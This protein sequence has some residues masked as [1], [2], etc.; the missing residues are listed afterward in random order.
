[1]GLSDPA[2]L[3]ELLVARATGQPDAVG[4]VFTD[5]D[6]A[7]LALTYRELDA[8]ARAA[9][10]QLQ[11]TGVEPGD[12]VMLLHP[13]GASYVTAFFGCLYAG[14]VAVPVYP[15]TNRAGIARVLAVAEDCAAT[16][17]MTDEVLLPAVQERLGDRSLRWLVP[18]GEETGWSRP[19]LTPDT[20]AF[21]QYT[22]GST[23]TPK[24]VLL[25]HG[26]LLHNSA[27]IAGVLA[28]D[29]HTRSVSWLPPYHDMGLIGGILQPLHSG[30]PGMLM[31]PMAF[32]HHPV[33]WLRA[34]SE[35]GATASAAPDFAYAE[36]VRRISDEELAGLDLSTWRLALVGA[37]PVRAP[38]LHAFAERFGPAGFRAEAF[39]PCYGLAEATL[40]VTGAASSARPVEL[41]VDRAELAGGSVVPAESGATLVGCGTTRGADLVAVV[42]PATGEE[43]PPGAVGEIWVSG[44]TVGAGYWANEK[45]TRRVFHARLAGSEHDWLR[46][47]DLGFLRD[48]ELFVTGRLKELIVVRGANHYPADIEQSAAS[49]GPGLAAGRAA[50]FAVDDGATERVVLV[51]EVARGFA[52]GQPAEVT[53]LV[54]AVREAVTRDHLLELSDVVLVRPG[55]VPR[56]SSGKVRRTACRE[57]YLAGTLAALTAEP[58]AP[59][60][61]RAAGPEDPVLGLVAETLQL[62]H[63]ALHPDRP[64]VGQG[65]D[66]L[67]AVRLRSALLSD[68]DTDVQLEWL[69]S[70]ATPAAVASASRGVRVTDP[71]P[72]LA[73]GAVAPA[74]S[75]QE[76][77]WLLDQIGAGAAYHIAGRVDW[78]SEPDVEAVRA[79]LRALVARHDALRTGFRLTPD[80]RVEQVVHHDVDFDVAIRQVPD[81]AALD[82]ECLRLAEQRFD[83]GAPPLLRAMLF[84]VTTGGRWV[85]ALC[86]HH[87]VADGA[88]AAVLARELNTL[89][90]DGPS[91]LPELP[92]RYADFAAWQRD[93]A[94]GDAL[95][96]QVAH[97]RDRLT[98]AVPLELP[99]DAAAGTDRSFAGKALPLT[100]PADL[101]AEV[102][103]LA[104]AEQVTPFMVLAAAWVTVLSRWADQ[105][106]VVIGTV[107]AGR[108]RPE[109]SEVVGFF[110]NTVPL[111]VNVDGEPTFR[112][113]L[114][115]IRETCLAAYANQDLPF[116]QIVRAARQDQDFSDRLSIVRNMLVL[117]ENLPPVA[118]AGRVS[119]LHTGTAQFDVRIELSPAAGGEL[120][121]LL[122]YSTDVLG[123][124]T[125]TGLGEGLVEVLRGGTADAGQ[126]VSRLPLM[127]ATA[128]S[129]AVSLGDGGPLR[130][131]F[132][133][134]VGWFESVV[135]RWGDGIAVVE[136]GGDQLSF[137]DVETRANQ[138]ARWL[139]RHGVERGSRVGI[140]LDRGQHLVVGLWATWKAGGVYVP[141]DPDSPPERLAG[142]AADARP[143]LV[144]T[145]RAARKRVP[146]NLPSVCLDDPEVRAEVAAEDT[147]APGTVLGPH[148]VA[149]VL[150]TS[151]STGKPKGATNTHGGFV[152]RLASYQHR[153]GLDSRQVSATKAPIGFDVSVPELVWPLLHGARMVLVAPGGH[154]DPAHLHE[155][156]DRHGVTV[157]NFV[158]S[159]LRPFVEHDHPGGHPA[160]ELVVSSGEELPAALAADF[161]RRYPGARLMNT[162]GPAEA[163]VEVVTH[164]VSGPLGAR[165]PLGRPLAGVPLFVLDR[166][167]SPVPQGMVGELYVGGVQVG[168]GYEGR[169]ELT[170]ARYLPSPFGDGERLYATGDRARW[171]DGGLLEYWGRNDFQVKVHGQ[172]VELGEVEVVLRECAGVA[173]AVVV[174]VPDQYGD[175]FLAAYVVAQA[176]RP[177][178]E[179]LRADLGVTLPKHMVP[180][181]FTWLDAIPLS[182]N[183]KVDRKALPPVT[184]QRGAE[185]AYVEPRDALEGQL[186]EIWAEVLGVA[187]IGVRDSFFDL[188]GHSLLATRVVSR[189]R[190]D[191]RVEL[192]LTDL[193][194]TDPTVERL[195]D[196][197]RERRVQQASRADLRE[198]LAMV[199]TLSDEEVA[200]RLAEEQGNVG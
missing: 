66:S 191:L 190:A 148:D 156:F 114:G 165:V 159:M 82:E 187:R 136:D 45:E 118:A 162:Y 28:P 195:A 121:G 55:S 21:L 34:I 26:N 133:S 154:R 101:M 178:V 184:L 176:E 99:A 194:T 197:I 123:E 70:A 80:G 142:M 122:E 96:G 147:S 173:D 32:L 23:A 8:A 68:H 74:S 103:R 67:R 94:A 90:S 130:T 33:R 111:R 199:A 58:V 125:A 150:F 2:D 15:P 7:E 183:G 77:L 89:I 91:A 78:D 42:D 127:S 146:P 139:S 87:L 193:L 137:R 47:G 83:L 72:R 181:V 143:V 52:Q 175:R 102:R 12:R 167:L 92:V 140:C 119:Q 19:A 157:S 164:E 112:E 9:A 20:V 40:F 86:V 113:L 180:A 151:G 97:W 129:R 57:Q 18:T 6:G 149:Y 50:A 64:L 49:A 100:I 16:V 85:L 124:L 106:D 107:T 46:T 39:L 158:P 54:R 155:V 48:G 35:F 65:L 73:D 198:V 76:R 192:P 152:N 115:R 10:A 131:E 59:V 166:S 22:S 93:Q 60:A 53:A 63:A 11:A 116:D 177:S 196:R 13:P 88:S 1:M 51:H 189:I 172:R 179:Q 128:L 108:S 24:G 84:Q 135:D 120:T 3:V 141:L 110:A 145:S 14:A 185:T 200:A 62:D 170:A 186:A 171:T 174:A 29:E 138:L 44:P 38:T 4:Y 95:A 61:E 126:P 109:L 43:R 98:G 169:P 132:D 5:G 25:S 117:R 104:A 17:A 134:V 56:T 27:V 71:V 160:L 168:H 37:E 31:S 153:L 36:C 188:G 161:L 81:D 163:A 144:L 182:P 79:A 75:G 41:T 105:T 69:L 30:F